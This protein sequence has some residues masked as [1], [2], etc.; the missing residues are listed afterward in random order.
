MPKTITL[1]KHHTNEELERELKFTK[2]GR[3]RLRI[4]AILLAQ[5]GFKSH[6][7]VKQLKIGKDTF[8][9][10][11]RWY[12]E[13]GLKGIKEVSKGG[14][15]EGNPIWDKNIFEDLYRELDAM[16]EY[17]SIPKMQEWIIE[18]H[19]VKIPKSTIEHRLKVNGYS[20]KS[21]RPNPYKGDKEE[22]DEFKKKPC[23][24]VFPKLQTNH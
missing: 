21:S 19:N 4:Q 14:R 5:E 7:I 20:F 10:W 15:A 24:R 8:F 23:W 3:Y 2:D 22:Q 17:W 1:K 13:R 9:K 6:E 12:N 18:K 11:K 16:E